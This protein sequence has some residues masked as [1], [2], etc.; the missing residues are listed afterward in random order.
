MANT[1]C[2]PTAHC[3]FEE[4]CLGTTDIRKGKKRE[5]CGSS[6]VA[7][8]FVHVC[9]TSACIQNKVPVCETAELFVT[10]VGFDNY[11][12]ITSLLHCKRVFPCSW[13]QQW[14]KQHVLRRDRIDEMLT[15]ET[16]HLRRYLAGDTKVPMHGSPEILEVP[17][18]SE[19]GPLVSLEVSH[20]AISEDSQKSLLP[21]YLQDNGKATRGCRSSGAETVGDVSALVLPVEVEPRRPRGRPKKPKDCLGARRP[22]GRPRKTEY[23]TK[24]K[25]NVSQRGRPRKG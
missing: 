15:A 23:V 8:H 13:E 7:G 11:R 10:R 2:Y 18:D 4:Q 6:H 20:G 24:N 14:L 25:Q 5:Q 12:L 21:L 1:K 19:C 17:S 16:I 22:R 9:S 3:F